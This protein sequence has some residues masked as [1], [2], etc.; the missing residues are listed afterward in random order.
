VIQWLH[1]VNILTRIVELEQIGH[2]L[3][4]SSIKRQNQTFN[5]ANQSLTRI[6]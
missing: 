4:S 3:L 2:I 1:A 6:T 5:A